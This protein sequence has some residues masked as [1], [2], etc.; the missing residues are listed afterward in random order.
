MPAQ[1]GVNNLHMVILKYVWIL[2]AFLLIEYNKKSFKA[3]V[4]MFPTSNSDFKVS[5]I[6]ATK[7][8]NTFKTKMS[9]NLF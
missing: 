4:L 1:F 7:Q 9:I 6:M 5:F 2:K 3:T 8:K